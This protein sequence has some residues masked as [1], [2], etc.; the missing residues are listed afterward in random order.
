M[1][2]QSNNK[3]DLCLAFGKKFEGVIEGILT[4]GSKIEVKSDRKW[5]ETGNI[6]IELECYNKPS[7]INV[8]EADFWVYC[9]T[10]DNKLAGAFIFEVAQLKKHL[11]KLKKENKLKKIYGGDGRRSLLA[12]IPI[13]NLHELMVPI[14]GRALGN[15]I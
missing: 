5:V 9:L 13:K 15:L 8:T 12:L 1:K 3:Y 7:G 11:H 4:G 10:T 2:S 14:R 6:A